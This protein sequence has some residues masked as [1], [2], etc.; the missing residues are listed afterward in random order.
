LSTGS[1][2][3]SSYPGNV[4]A[5]SDGEVVAEIDPAAT[6][7]PI[8]DAIDVVN[9]AS[10]KGEIYVPDG[11]ETAG[12]L[13]GFS[14]MAIRG[15]E[16]RESRVIY[17]GGAADPPLIRADAA[18]NARECLWDNIQLVGPGSGT[19]SPEAIRFEDAVAQFG[20]GNFK[21]TDFGGTTNNLIEMSAGHAFGARWE[22]LRLT[23]S[24]GK[25]INCSDGGAILSIGQL[26]AYMDDT[27]LLL[28]WQNGTHLRVAAVNIGGSSG[29]LVIDQPS[30][31]TAQI[32]WLNHEPTGSQGNNVIQL[33]RDG[34]TR[35]GHVQHNNS[36]AG[37][38]Q[39]VYLQ[40]NCG[41]KVIGSVVDVHNN[42][43]RIIAVNNTTTATNY[44]FGDSADIDNISGS[45]I[46]EPIHCFGDGVFKISSGAG[47]DGGTN[48][49]KYGI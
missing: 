30:P 45:T 42:S 33:N 39:I 5:V 46:A 11:V 6:T 3:N 41:N 34:L 20:L 19:D 37:V 44:H 36:S 26:S 15:S 8:Q 9:A 12:D 23:N 29:G 17:N 16:G 21:I 13:T 14:K 22:F 31:K 28:N 1:F 7:A 10:G 40:N 48:D 43:S 4:R 47:Y 24:S 27:S 35:I 25:G 32:D 49:V 18:S 2:L 38:N